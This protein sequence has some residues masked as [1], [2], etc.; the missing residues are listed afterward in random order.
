MRF[1]S[2]K[3]TES[4]RRLEDLLG[5]LDTELR[6]QLD[7]GSSPIGDLL[8]Q[9]QR[10]LSDARNKAEQ[11]ARLARIVHSSP[12]FIGIISARGQAVY[13]NPAGRAMIGL[14]PDED[15][16]G[17]SAME[18]LDEE[19]AAMLQQRIANSKFRDGMQ[20]LIVMKSRTG[21]RI[22]CMRTA[23]D[24]TAPDGTLEFFSTIAKDI[25]DQIQLIDALRESEERFRL[26]VE[27]VFHGL[28]VSVDR[29]AVDCNREAAAMFGYTV[30]E[31]EGKTPA[32]LLTTDSAALV[33]ER[34]AEDYDRIYEVTGVRK[35][36]TEFPVQL[37]GTTCTWKGQK[38]RVTA[39]RDISA[40]QKAE[41]EQKL[42]QR[43]LQQSRTLHAVGRFAAGVAHDFS[44]TL[45]GISLMHQN[46]IDAL[47]AG[48]AD[49][50][51]MLTRLAEAEEA[52]Q[53]AKDLARQMLTLAQES[54]ARTESI[55]ANDE[56]ESIIRLM[57]ASHP[58]HPIETD[59]TQDDVLIADPAQLRQILQNLIGNAAQ[60]SPEGR[61]I[62][63]QTR[64]EIVESL[65]PTVMG[66]MPPGEYFVLQITD[67][68]HG[69]PKE[70]LEQ[71]F[72]PFFTTRALNG[73]LGLG[74]ATVNRAVEAHY[75][76]IGVESIP[77]NGST[78]SIYL[79]LPNGSPETMVNRD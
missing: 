42:L 5:Q 47:S 76:F 70:N 78:F 62:R 49:A 29:V 50:Q 1:D 20:G 3:S 52:I 28:I 68:G 30:E 58:G 38:A 17:I 56:I 12:D 15:L 14:S 11:N 2:R 23:V 25:R 51:D 26:L 57:S 4:L 40:E 9:T 41:E 39:L 45:L 35:D 66:E 59:L 37:L 16:S 75:G 72:D 36:G 8:E 46:M 69:V 55:A 27:G 71:I 21:E 74:L 54:R 48:S 60:N 77:D 65:T 19:S 24:H 31:M 10:T 73:G 32:I 34:V 13:L 18:Y 67:H 7:P 43:Q 22:T 64:R 53:Q 44:N 63:V 79:P 33:K 6:T 61:P